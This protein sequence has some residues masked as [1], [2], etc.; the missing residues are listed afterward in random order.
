[1]AGLICCRAWESELLLLGWVTRQCQTDQTAFSTLSS[2]VPCQHISSQRC[3]GI[4][5]C[6]WHHETERWAKRW[7]SQ[8]PPAA[9]L[10]SVTRIP[11][12]AASGLAG[13]SLS[14]NTLQLLSILRV[15]PRPQL[16]LGCADESPQDP[17]DPL[18][19]EKLP[20][21][22]PLVLNSLWIELHI[23]LK[24]KPAHLPEQTED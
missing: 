22:K 13:A 24:W 9:C 19:S 8:E 3:W 2:T 10:C 5:C 18:A 17:L 21:I 20:E 7:R 14:P 16:S 6:Q 23:H 15:C 1:M 11:G 12:G 4:W